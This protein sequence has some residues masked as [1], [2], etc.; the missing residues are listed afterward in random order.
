MQYLKIM[1]CSR[2]SYLNYTLSL[3]RIFFLNVVFYFY[4]YGVYFLFVFVFI[5]FKIKVKEFL[6]KCERKY[7]IYGQNH[8]VEL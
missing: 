4:V 7:S 3:I 5:L 6:E 2:G 1:D 8:R